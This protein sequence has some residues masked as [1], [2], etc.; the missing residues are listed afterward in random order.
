M[1][2]MLKSRFSKWLAFGALA[3]A[4]SAAIPARQASAALELA[5]S[6]DGSVPTFFAPEIGQEVI[7]PLFV[8]Q[9][10]TTD[11]LSGPGCALTA[12]GL[13]GSFDGQL[14]E[15]VGFTPGAGFFPGNVDSSTPGLIL[16]S[17]FAFT[18]VTATNDAVALGNLSL[19]ILGGGEFELGFTDRNPGVDDFTTTGPTPGLDAELFIAPDGG[20]IMP[21]VT[22]TAVPEPGSFAL[23]GVIGTGVATYRRR[24]RKVTK[25]STEA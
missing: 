15:T 19:R 18:P 3:V 12:F 5:F 16:F 4:L 7:V 22:I 14:A 25:A 24:L 21:S 2:S 17:G 6:D 20:A 23:L 1:N 8:R 9:T 13:Q 10:G 11:T